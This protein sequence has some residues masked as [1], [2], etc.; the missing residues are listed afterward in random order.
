MSASMPGAPGKSSRRYAAVGAAIVAMAGAALAFGAPPA[1]ADTV[2]VNYTCTGTGAPSGVTTSQITVTA[3][4]T[5]A[6]GST[7]DLQ[8]SLSTA[9]TAP[10]ALPANGVQGQVVINLG[11]ASSGSVTATGLTDP[12]GIAAG[13]PVVLTG[14]TASVQLSNAGSVTFTPGNTTVTVSEF[15]ATVNCAVSGTAPVAA[16]TQVS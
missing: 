2:S 12:S 11:G 9:Q 4:A 3:P 16:T 5:A 14:G 7:V 6:V 1:M 8:V 13:S 10:I 15:G